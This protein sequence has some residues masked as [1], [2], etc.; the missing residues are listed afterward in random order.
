MPIV[1]SPSCPTHYLRNAVITFK[2]NDPDEFYTGKVL[3]RYHRSG[4]D[5]WNIVWVDKT[6]S[7][8]YLSLKGYERGDWKFKKKGVLSSPG[9]SAKK[10]S[11]KRKA[12]RE[13]SPGK[14]KTSKISPRRLIVS[15]KVPEEDNKLSDYE[16]QRLKRIAENKAKI[17][18][19]GLG[20]AMHSIHNEVVNER[21]RA[22]KAQNARR[23]RNRDANRQR[24]RSN[25]IE[26]GPKRRSSRLSG[27]A[28]VKY[29]ED[30]SRISYVGEEEISVMEAGEY[31]KLINV[32]PKVKT[33]GHYS[34]WLNP[35]LIKS[36]GFAQTAEEAWV[37]GGGG[38]FS[39]KSPGGKNKKGGLNCKDFAYKMKF[40]N[41]NAYFYRHTAPGVPHRFDADFPWTQEEEEKFLDVAKKYGCGDKWG[42]FSS[43]LPGRVGY[44]CSQYYR[45][46][47]IKEGL[48]Q[49]PNFAF[50]TSGDPVY[51]GRKGSKRG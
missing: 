6:S 2:W 31:L 33:D 12:E 25:Q 26:R 34:G 35:E 8:I 20:Q 37:R 7:A 18:E 28:P 40:K 13:R 39:F 9:S 29:T 42:L 15:E 5:W 24:S 46:H 50:S 36:H 19:L 41:P 27:V 22:L 47:M 17:E 21:T 49:D 23:K 11:G 44:Q 38:K 4:A 32:V 1:S 48:V 14:K 45:K 16:V 10:S 3:N 51:V 43:W 30:T